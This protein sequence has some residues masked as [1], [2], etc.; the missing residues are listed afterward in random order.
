MKYAMLAIFGM[1]SLL[2]VF[3]C[4]DPCGDL[5]KKK[6]ECSKQEDITK[7]TC[8]AAVD[9]VI[10]TGD[11]TACKAYLDNWDASWGKTVKK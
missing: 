3:G 8:E 5:T 10:K 4:S 6:A 9:A 11:K 7:G 2:V 1:T